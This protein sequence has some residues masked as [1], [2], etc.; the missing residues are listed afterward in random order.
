MMLSNK[1]NN[2]APSAPDVRFAAAGFD[3]R[4]VLK[5]LKCQNL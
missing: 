1:H 4:Y 3:G 5:E 2:L